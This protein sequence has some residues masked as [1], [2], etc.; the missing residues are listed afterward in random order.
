MQNEA[1]GFAGKFNRS[2]YALSDM[3]KIDSICLA[4]DINDLTYFKN[5]Y[6]MLSSDWKVD[7]QLY[8]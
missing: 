5:R 7:G 8:L 3:E 6:I 4:I 1:N 2:D